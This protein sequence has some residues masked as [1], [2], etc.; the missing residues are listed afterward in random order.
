M[1]TKLMNFA[2]ML[3]FFRPLGLTVFGSFRFSAVKFDS[4]FA[5]FLAKMIKI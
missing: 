4:S 1:T 3:R 2:S 5:C